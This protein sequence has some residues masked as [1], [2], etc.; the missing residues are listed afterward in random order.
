M[1]DWKPFFPD[2]RKQARAERGTGRTKLIM[3][4]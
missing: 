2:K 1:K 3:R 4:V